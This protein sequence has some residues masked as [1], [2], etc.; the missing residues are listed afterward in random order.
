MNK[1]YIYSFFFL[2]VF[3]FSCEDVIDVDVES[4][5]GDLVIDAWIDN[6]AQ[7]QQI[8]LT[9][10]QGYFDNSTLIGAEGAAVAVTNITQ[11]VEH[12]FVEA[13]SGVYRWNANT[14]GQLGQVGDELIL[15]IDYNGEQYSAQTIIK[16]IPALDSI[17]QEFVDDEVF[18]DDGIYTEFFARD[19]EGTGDAYW[20]KTFK[21]GQFLNDAQELN[22]AFD[23]GF[24]A[25]SMIDGIIFIPPI[26]DLVNELD[27]DGL[28]IPWQA[29]EEIKVELHSLSEEAFNFLEITRDQINNGSNG[30]FALPLANVRSNISKRDGSSALGFFNIAAVSSREKT[31][32]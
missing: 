20:I 11:Q 32:Q 19:F 30:I 24:D 6:R 29:G 2:I 10:A 25:G 3:L 23:A 7:D 16:R 12:P 17:T 27:S 5:A 22:I 18:L 13:S 21:N 31:I 28:Q 9:L 14:T 8:R 4:A 26:R 15:N 1:S